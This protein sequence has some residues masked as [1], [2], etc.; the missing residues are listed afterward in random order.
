MIQFGGDGPLFCNCA[1]IV[2][3][4]YQSLALSLLATI[5]VCY[6]D[7]HF[8]NSIPENQHF[9]ENRK[10]KVFEILKHLQHGITSRTM[11]DQSQFNVR[12]QSKKILS[13]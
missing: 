5:F 11:I 9:I 2:C 13:N 12:D 4:L 1:L 10:R 7:I 8:V 3:E 6:S